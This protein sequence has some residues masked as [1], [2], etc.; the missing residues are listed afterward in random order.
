M[1]VKS[2]LAKAGPHSNLQ[3][4]SRENKKGLYDKLV[5]LGNYLKLRNEGSERDLG[6]AVTTFLVSLAASSSCC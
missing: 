3:N 4:L 1:E 2:N 5:N 6:S